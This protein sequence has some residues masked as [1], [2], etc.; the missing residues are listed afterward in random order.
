MEANLMRLEEIMKQELDNFQSLCGLALREQRAIV[1]D[2]L[3]EM[4]QCTEEMQLIAFEN[5]E[6]ERHRLQLMREL[7]AQ[8]GMDTQAEKLTLSQV[9]GHLA[10][11]WWEQRLDEL[12]ER[13]RRSVLCL[14]RLN[15]TNV[16]LLRYSLQFLDELLR[17]VLGNDKQGQNKLYSVSGRRTDKGTE[18]RAL[19]N[20]KG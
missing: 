13:V 17:T 4:L 9:I 11:D 3:D 19:L 8:L 14:Q 15:E 2:E 6:L 12:G 1:A 16:M 7:A 10:D 20:L 18:K 5:A